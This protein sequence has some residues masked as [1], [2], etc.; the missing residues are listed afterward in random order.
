MILVGGGLPGNEYGAGVGR[1][2]D[3]VSGGDGRMGSNND[4]QSPSGQASHK[5]DLDDVVTE[6]EQAYL[7]SDA[8]AEAFAGATWAIAAKDIGFAE[9]V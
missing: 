5:R 1:P 4:G 3:N 8:R 2:R 6:L 7:A 9:P